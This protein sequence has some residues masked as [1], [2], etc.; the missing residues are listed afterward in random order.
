MQNKLFPSKEIKLNFQNLVIR[1]TFPAIKL[2]VKITHG[3]TY[4]TVFI[5]FLIMN[6]NYKFLYNKKNE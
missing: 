5:N 4:I 1:F 3:L 2:E 6:L